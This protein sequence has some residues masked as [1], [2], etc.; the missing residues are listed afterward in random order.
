MLS[1]GNNIPALGLPPNMLAKIGTINIPTPAMP[2]LAIPTKSAH[3]IIQY[4][5]SVLS[6]KVSSIEIKLKNLWSS[7][8][9]D[10][11]IYTL[12]NELYRANF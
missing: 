10:F 4:H 6:S 12:T 7:N 3:N 2:V 9:K 11:D 8:Y 1:I 5:W